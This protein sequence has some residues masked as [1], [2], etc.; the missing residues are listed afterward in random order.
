LTFWILLLGSAIW[1]LALAGVVVGANGIAYIGQVS[2]G[3]QFGDLV[4]ADA[5]RYWVQVPVVAVLVFGVLFPVWTVRHWRRERAAR[6]APPA[7]DVTYDGSDRAYFAAIGWMLTA[8]ATSWLLF[9]EDDWAVLGWPLSAAA[10]A[11]GLHKALRARR[12]GRTLRR[13]AGGLCGSCGY[14][15]RATPGRCPE[16]GKMEATPGAP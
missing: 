2:V 13:R 3:V 11:T 4:V 9:Y 15:L 8:L 6:L 10:G 5:Y 1:L 7:D 12:L 16:C 14:D